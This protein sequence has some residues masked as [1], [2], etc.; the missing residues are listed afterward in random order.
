MFHVA[1]DPGDFGV[2]GKPDFGFLGPIAVRRM[3]ATQIEDLSSRASTHA[4]ASRRLRPEAFGCRLG[5]KFLLA[6]LPATWDRHCSF[7]NSTIRCLFAKIKK[8][9]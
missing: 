1:I 4:F 6:S 8:N 7:E 2:P 9:W 3:R 5:L